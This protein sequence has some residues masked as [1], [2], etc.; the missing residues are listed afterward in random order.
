[1]GG[2]HSWTITAKTLRMNLKSRAYSEGIDEPNHVHMIFQVNDPNYV[3][4]M[5]KNNAFRMKM[6]AAGVVSYPVTYKFLPAK[7]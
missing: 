4:K 7:A 6:L 5:E 1:M 2:K 3:Q